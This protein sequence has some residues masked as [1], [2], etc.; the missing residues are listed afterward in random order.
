MMAHGLFVC[1]LICCMVLFG[2][3][4]KLN[5]CVKVTSYWQLGFFLRKPL[6]RILAQNGH[7]IWY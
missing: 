3:H 6:S 5:C 7:N 2:D 4:F 1:F